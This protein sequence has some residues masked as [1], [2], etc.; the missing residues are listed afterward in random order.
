MIIDSELYPVN[1]DE[2][3]YW[4]D[5]LQDNTASNISKITG[6][7]INYVHKVLNKYFNADRYIKEFCRCGRPLL[8]VR[9]NN[10]NI[11]KICYNP[12]KTQ[13]NEKKN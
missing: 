1:E 12:L 11:C 7:D 8:N 10:M 2:V 4:F 3:M 5:I 13:E 9:V 6:F